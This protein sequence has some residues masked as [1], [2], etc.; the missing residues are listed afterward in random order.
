MRLLR[1]L[2]SE[3]GHRRTLPLALAGA[4]A[5]GLAGG[6]AGCG[7]DEPLPE[8][9]Q[10]WSLLGHLL[11]PPPLPAEIRAVREENL[12]GAL[13]DRSV[14]PEDPEHWIWI[15]RHHAYLG[16]YRDAVDAFSDGL[17]RFPNDMR[18]LR[19]RGHRWITLRELDRAVADLERAT[20]EMGEA[21]AEIEPDGLPNPAG[22]PLTTLAFNAWYHLA[23]AQTLQGRLADARASWERTLEVSDNPD[24]QAA[25]RYWLHLVLRRLGEDEEAARV[26]AGVSAADELLENQTYRDLLLHFRGELPAEAVLPADGEGLA[27]VT[28]L[29][30]L[31]AHA[32][33]EAD[34]VEAMRRFQEILDRPDQW[35]AFGFIAAEAEVAR[36]GRG[37]GQ[38]R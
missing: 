14:D 16:D 11:Y 32:L 30:G 2:R 13:R 17:E 22:I 28:A 3:P 23:L 20:R 15:G 4:L 34:T 36:Q 33:L 21:G 10:A 27:S 38:G 26:A 1:P 6:V 37:G 19:H 8:G 31:G 29:Y 25:S 35:P 7:D 9:A 24:L 5:M 18:F 12:E